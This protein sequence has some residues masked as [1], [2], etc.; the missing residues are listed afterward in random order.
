MMRYIISCF[1][2]L[3]TSSCSDMD[4]PPELINKLR[5]ILTTINSQDGSDSTPPLL[6]E[7]VSLYF[8]FLAPEEVETVSLELSSS[9]SALPNTLNQT[10]LIRFEAATLI[11]LSSLNHIIVSSIWQLPSNTADIKGLTGGVAPFNYAVKALADG[12]EKE[13][14]GSFL[15]YTS[16]DAPTYNWNFDDAG[17][18]L[19]ESDSSK[20]LSTESVS[21][22][23]SSGN[24]QNEPVKIAWFTS[25]GE[26]LN[27]RS[28]ETTWKPNEA[29]EH[30]LIFT[31]RGKSSKMSAIRSVSVSL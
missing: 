9:A 6:G 26:I 11:K 15:V 22:K 3:I 31:I 4:S 12:Y 27:R 16:A 14:T 30:S 29:G 13:I 28:V 24:T 10:H 17:I 2:I 21:I 18:E 23:A 8:H 5:P 25:I 19:P 20:A 7:T 1:L